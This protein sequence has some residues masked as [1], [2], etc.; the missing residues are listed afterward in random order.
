MA[1]A[2]PTDPSPPK[3]M[4][5]ELARAGLLGSQNCRWMMA[6][7]KD[8][9]IP[10]PVSAKEACI[11][12]GRRSLTAAGESRR[13]KT[14]GE[15]A[16]TLAFG[17]DTCL[18]RKQPWKMQPRVK[19]QMS[20]LMAVATWL[21]PRGASRCGRNWLRAYCTPLLEITTQ[22]AEM[23]SHLSSL[24]ALGGAMAGA[25]LM[26]LV[27]LSSSLSQAYACLKNFMLIQWRMMKMMAV[28]IVR[29]TSRE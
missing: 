13:A 20:R 2:M 26:S 12:Q 21:C 5:T 23:R 7:R 16:S 10:N 27:P 6:L 17:L 14:S 22:L 11:S 9:P 24:P 29:G 18:E 8:G 28:G 25:L 3:N 15:V 19:K 1:M 4:P